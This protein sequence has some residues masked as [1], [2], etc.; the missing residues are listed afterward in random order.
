MQTAH[1]TRGDRIL[2]TGARG[3]LGSN[4][5]ARARA[6]GYDVIPTCR[7]GASGI[8]PLDICDQRSV[9]AAFEDFRPSVVI[10]CAAYGVNYA[11]QDFDSA[12]A[13]NVH[14]SLRVLATAVRCGVRCFLH[15][16][17]CA[18]Y[19]SKPGPIV[20]ESSLAPTASYGASKAAATLLMSE[21]ARS[22]GAYLIVA[23]PFG[24]WGPAESDYRLFPQ[25][26]DACVRRRALKLTSCE[27]LRDYTYVE[28][29]AANIL[30]LALMP[31]S[32]A[33]TVVNVATGRGVL[34]R[35]LVLAVARQLQG[36]HLMEFGALPYRPTEMPSLVA[37][38]DRLQGL[39]GPPP[40]TDFAEGVRRMLASRQRNGHPAN[41]THLAPN[42]ARKEPTDGSAANLFRH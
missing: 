42:S 7:G 34:L 27:V 40:T 10:H 25:I 9:T 14:G 36:E 17:S 26:I 32:S 29:M 22:L 1:P 16:G 35:D 24:I 23:R 3:F 37:N 21:L 2:I 39:L 30:G 6:F 18:E 12:V 19:G 15:I 4:I 41:E 5:T 38:I 31:A 13:V 33:S 20:E 28:D 8:A 11:E